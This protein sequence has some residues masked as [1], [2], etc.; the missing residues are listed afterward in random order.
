M[1]NTLA[2]SL[3]L[4]AITALAM[5]VNYGTEGLHVL[6]HTLLVDFLPFM[7]LVGVPFAIA[8][9]INI[10]VVARP[11]PLVNVAL[12]TAGCLLGAVLGTIGASVLMIR[13]ILAVNKPRTHKVHTVMATIWLVCNMGGLLTPIGPPLIMG[14][15][16]SDP[17]ERVPFFWP[18]QNLWQFWAVASAALLFVYFVWD[19]ILY[20]KENGGSIRLDEPS[21]VN[22]S[23]WKNIGI[24]LL[25]V[26]AVVM[27]DTPIR[28]AVLVGLG[29]LAYFT[30]KKETRTENGFKW[31]PLKVVGSLFLGIFVTMAPALL[32]MAK[33]APDLGVDT[34]MKFFAASGA[35]SSWLDNAPTYLVFCAIGRALQL[36]NEIAG[37]PTQI[38]AA[39]S[40]GAASWGLGTYIGNA[41]NLLVKEVAEYD[42]VEMPSFIGYFAWSLVTALPV[43]VLVGWVFF[44]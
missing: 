13:P 6:G 5:G 35:L 33:L 38:L 23:G 44:G 36:G 9:G 27:L 21:K 40:A 11:T 10:K 34:P 41:P 39:I 8:G 19:T 12:L 37:M 32:V 15:L 7:I 24:L 28:E 16:R 29:A 25:V 18:A 22:I 20:K 14:F 1:R 17:A 31:T 30:T 4:S 26:V 43:L 42:D 2:L 3:V